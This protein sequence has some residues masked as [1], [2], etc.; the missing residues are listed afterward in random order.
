VNN[1]KPISI[2]IPVLNEEKYIPNLLASL[3]SQ[4]NKNF[5]VIVVDGR[6]NDN[7]VKVVKKFTKLLPKLTVIIAPHKGVSYQRNLGAAAAAFDTILF[8]DADINIPYDFLEKAVSEF[9]KKKADIATTKSL[10]IHGEYLDYVVNILFNN[11]QQITKNIA[12][13]AYGWMIM[14]KKKVHDKVHGFDEKLFFFEDSDYCQRIVEKGGKFEILSSTFPYV[15][16]RRMDAETRPAFYRKMLVYYFYSMLYDRYTAQEKISY[17]SGE[18]SKVKKE[19]KKAALSYKFKK[20][21][22]DIKKKL[23]QIQ[24]ELAK[25]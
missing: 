14:V 15:S 20:L 1:I 21:N 22:S 9:Y 24:D 25:I 8:L 16:A 23:L 12:P 2:V 3:S 13:V 5:E 19:M 17:K 4:T 7:T 18:F 11:Y 6:S 10:P